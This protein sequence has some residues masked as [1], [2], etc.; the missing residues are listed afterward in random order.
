[1]H[2]KSTSKFILTLDSATVQSKVWPHLTAEWS[3][4]QCLDWV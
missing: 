1:M 2:V 3:W 4:D